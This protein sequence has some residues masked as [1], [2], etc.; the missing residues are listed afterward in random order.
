MFT[1]TSPLTNETARWKSQ[2]GIF[3]KVQQG[4]DGWKIKSLSKR[5]TVPYTFFCS[6]VFHNLSSYILHKYYLIVP[7]GVELKPFVPNFLF[8]SGHFDGLT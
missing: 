4:D 8:K 5:N 6:L 7:L 3:Q 2:H 1:S